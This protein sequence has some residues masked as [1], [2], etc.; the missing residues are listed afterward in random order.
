MKNQGVERCGTWGPQHASQ[1]ST[2]PPLYK[3]V[4]G[5]GEGVPNPSG[6]VGVL[7]VASDTQEGRAIR[8][9]VITRAPRPGG[10]LMVDG[11]SF[12]LLRTFNFTRKDGS[13][14]RLLA[15]RSHCP[16]CGAEFKTTSVLG[17]HTPTR[18]CKRHRA[19]G[20]PVRGRGPVRIAIID[21]SPAG[22]SR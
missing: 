18:R 17:G 9:T 2:P 14:G 1:P 15:W 8:G 13:S 7:A 10:R 11:Q 4:G 6:K 19:P 3:G 21:P 16:Q 22:V 5:G 12:E 20:K